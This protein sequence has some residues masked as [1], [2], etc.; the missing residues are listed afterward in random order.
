MIR[1]F[2]TFTITFRLSNV[3][4]PTGVLYSN[5][6]G[7]LLCISRLGYNNISAWASR[8]CSNVMGN[9]K[10]SNRGMTAVGFHV[11]FVPNCEVF[12]VVFDGNF[13]AFF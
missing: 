7:A 9:A 4:C 12:G 11:F 2:A 1:N 6:R 13:V 8:C 3:R 5:L 10:A